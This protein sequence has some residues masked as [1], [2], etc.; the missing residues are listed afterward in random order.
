MLFMTYTG[1]RMV[2][3]HCNCEAYHG[4]K[5]NIR[6]ILSASKLPLVNK[7][8]HEWFEQFCALSKSVSGTVHMVG[9]FIHNEMEI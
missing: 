9:R 6:N 2:K 1:K 5:K 3:F 7:A 4:A 8:S